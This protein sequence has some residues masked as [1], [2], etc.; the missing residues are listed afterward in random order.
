MAKF[1]VCWG[2][3]F[4]GKVSQLLI[5]TVR[6]N[7]RKAVGYLVELY[8]GGEPTSMHLFKS[9]EEQ[10]AFAE[11]LAQREHCAMWVEHEE[12]EWETNHWGEWQ[13][14]PLYGDAVEQIIVKVK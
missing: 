2:K 12:N 1:V 8:E 5:R 3:P 14:C 13:A 9:Y 4:T 10:G 7:R 11:Y 6:Q